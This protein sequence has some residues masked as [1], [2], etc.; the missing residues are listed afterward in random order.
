MLRFDSVTYQA[1]D[2]DAH[3]WILWRSTHR[4]WALKMNRP[5]RW[6]CLV[7][8]GLHGGP[9]SYDIADLQRYILSRKQRS[10]SFSL[11]YKSEAGWE[12]GLSIKPGSSRA[13]IASLAQQPSP[14][15]SHQAYTAIKCWYGVSRHSTSPD[16]RLQSTYDSVADFDV[17]QLLLHRVRVVVSHCG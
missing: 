9:L 13:E 7:R 1:R 8:C 17:L 10:H 5:L 3:V 11:Q 4:I 16:G 6:Y 15:P 12:T 14:R 2:W